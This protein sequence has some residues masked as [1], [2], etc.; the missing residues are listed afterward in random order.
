M[1]G[2]FTPLQKIVGAMNAPPA[3]WK[4]GQH[5]C[6][7]PDESFLIY[8]TQRAGS[9]WDSDSNLFVCFRKEDGAWS[10][11]YDLGGRLNLPGDNWLATISPDNQYLFFCNRWD[12][13][14]VSLRILDE[15]KNSQADEKAR[16]KMD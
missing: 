8:D 14:W 9:E 1:D 15:L 5:S 10:D 6:I 2:K 12:I 13:Y 11:A 3:G 16:E 4:R 7:A